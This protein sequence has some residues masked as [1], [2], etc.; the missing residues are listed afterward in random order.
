MG[1]FAAAVRYTFPV[2]CSQD[3]QIPGLFTCFLRANHREF[4][5]L[6]ENTLTFGG[7]SD[8]FGFTIS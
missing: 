6:N 2:V 4:T 3:A 8:N 7:N 5:Q 1:G